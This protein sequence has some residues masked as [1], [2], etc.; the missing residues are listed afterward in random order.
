MNKAI[1][2]T[3]EL[4]HNHKSSINYAKARCALEQ[5]AREEQQKIATIQKGNQAL[6]TRLSRNLNMFI[7]ESKVA[8]IGH[9]KGKCEPKGNGR[10]IKFFD[11]SEAKY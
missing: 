2:D 8:L 1:L 9:L 10:V 4:N 5:M 3:V 7:I 6:A 11:G